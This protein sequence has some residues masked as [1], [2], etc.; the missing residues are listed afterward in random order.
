LADHE[1]K[2]DLSEIINELAKHAINTRLPPRDAT[3]LINIGVGRRGTAATAN[4][5]TSF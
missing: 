2:D 4:R 5:N 1:P 3:R